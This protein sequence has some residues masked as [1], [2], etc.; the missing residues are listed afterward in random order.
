[1]L[2]LVDLLGPSKEGGLLV[3]LAA[4]NILLV[5]LLQFLP[6]FQLSSP[7]IDPVDCSICCCLPVDWVHQRLLAVLL[8]PLFQIVDGSDPCLV[9]YS[10][11]MHDLRIVEQL[12]LSFQLW[13]DV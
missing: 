12:L 1:M 7:K 2:F 8:L 11:P 4:L 5:D 9:E 6:V 3:F 13:C 10:G